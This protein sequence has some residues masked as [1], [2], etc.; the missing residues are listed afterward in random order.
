MHHF[1]SFGLAARL[2]TGFGFLFCL[3]VGLTAYSTGQVAQID[4]K[5]ATINDVNSVK[6]RYAINYRGSVHDRAIAVRDVT[7]VTSEAERMQ[8]VALIEKL[9]ASYADNEKRM[10]EMVA[11]LAGA[12][13]EE[14]TILA[15]IADI[16]A[17][18]NPLVA[19][20]ISL[21][22]KGDGSAARRVLLEQ[23]R[24]LF[25]AWLGA[26]NKFIDYQEALNK[27]VGGEVRD[28]ASHFKSLA[29]TALGIAAVLSLIAAVLAARSII[30]PLSRL[31]QS[32][33]AMAA[34]N[35][36][37]DHDLEARGD[38]IGTLARAVATLRDTI[39]KKA[40][41]EADAEAKRTITERQRLEEEAR[42]RS[43]LA[44][45]TS[46]AVNQLADALQAL[47]AGDLTREIKS[48]F[49][50][51]LDKLRVDFNCAVANL[52]DAMHKVA[53]NARSIAAGAQEIRSASDDLSKRTE[54]QAASVE[55]TAAALEEITTTVADS[56][57][58]AQ[59]AGQLVRQTR[60]NAE[61]SG[62]VVRDAVVA[63]GSIESSA[64]EIGT[65]IGV[66]DE[67]AFQTN[68]LA[69]NAGV[70]AARAG[71]AGKGFAVVAQ[72]VR[73]LAQRSAKAAK[74]IKGLIN[75]SN[76]HVKSGVSLVAE[77]GKALH[78][79][80]AQVQQVDGNV[81]AIVQASKEQAIGLR[82][83][84]TAVNTMDQGTQ[85]NAAMVEE[86]TAAA[87]S[88]AREAD[89]LFELVRQF[90]IGT[91]VTFKQSLVAPGVTNARPSAS[92][93]LQMIAK[94]N[95]SFNGNAALA[96]EWEEF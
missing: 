26:I 96:S 91:E 19:E 82:E 36:E 11:S 54:Q 46:H 48:P 90:K 4:S 1:K 60:E 14:K 71:D 2:A 55:E 94:I 72:E 25:V 10:A 87:H 7:L 37:G 24:P 38:E 84:N 31:Q 76:T 92:P 57:N 16:Q 22:N 49:I 15:E 23:A 61:H 44:E 56:S 32:L 30:G 78:Q 81:G 42:E 73:E 9:A 8:A 28:T 13:D 34:G 80:V 27:S 33:K 12:T 5:L 18:T 35:P 50:T 39:F 45:Q 6:Q 43:A 58:R 89:A 3:M 41:R 66:I 64:S 59:E 74:E 83:I 70:E 69:L 21:Q 95:H 67:I 77:T 17:K 53:E 79:I 93:A 20:I 88:L 75:A 65:I 86:A 52:R 62:I 63:M 40:E 85:Q 47:A 51:S 29:F 68:L